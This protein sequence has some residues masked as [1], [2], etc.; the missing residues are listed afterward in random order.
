MPSRAP[1]WWSAWSACVVLSLSGVAR[2]EETATMAGYERAQDSA[3]CPDA[4]AFREAV[5]RRLGREGFVDGDAT[6]NTAPRVVRVSLR[7]RGDWFSVELSLDGATRSVRARRCADAV[8]AAALTVAI[9]LDPMAALGAI[10]PSRSARTNTGARTTTTT[11]PPALPAGVLAGHTTAP[12]EARDGEAAPPVVLWDPVWRRPEP[13]ALRALELSLSL[14]LRGG[15]A[16]GAAPLLARPSLAVSV[17]LRRGDWSITLDTA[18]DLPGATR[19]PATPQ[20][21]ASALPWTA[22]LG[23][24]RAAPTAIAPFVCIRATAGAL[25]AWG[26]GYVTD[27]FTV[28]PLVAGGARAGVDFTLSRRWALRAAVDGDLWL[29]RP[30]LVVDDQRANPVF[31]APFASVSAWFGARLWIL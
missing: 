13:P 25:F 28:L 6:A 18:A 23:A 3:V 20:A 7:R 12:S 15:I 8:N 30:V 10:T 2:A 5:R 16:P 21:T 19:D 17:G 14:G 29:V 4:S 9:A 22:S 1:L 24:C 11:A 26:A 27:G 31:R